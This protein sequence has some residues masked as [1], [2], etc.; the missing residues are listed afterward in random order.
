MLCLRARPRPRLAVACGF[1]IASAIAVAR[2]Y[3]HAHRV[4]E[5]AAGMVVGAATTACYL[6]WCGAPQLTARLRVYAILSVALVGALMYGRHAPIE[7]AIQT[8]GLVRSRWLIAPASLGGR[9]HARFAWRMPA[10]DLGI[11]TPGA[12][13]RRGRFQETYRCRSNPPPPAHAAPS[14]KARRA[15][16]RPANSCARKSSACARARPR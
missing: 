5:V 16:R 13:G 4:S 8:P 7:H 9:M 15:R 6:R 1:A 2:V 12:D 11:A 10:L 3:A 14:A